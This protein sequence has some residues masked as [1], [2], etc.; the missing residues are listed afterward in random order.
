[1]KMRDEFGTFLNIS[2]QLKNYRKKFSGMGTDQ[3]ISRL[4][5]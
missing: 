3:N 4:E 2:I 1:M 5:H